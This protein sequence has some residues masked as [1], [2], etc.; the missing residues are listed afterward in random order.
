MMLGYTCIRNTDPV[1]GDNTITLG[2]GLDALQTVNGTDVK[3]RFTVPPSGNVEIDFSCMVYASS[4]ELTFSLST[5]ATG[6]YSAL[7]AIHEYDGV[8]IKPDETDYI[9]ANPKWVVS[10]LTPGTDTTWYIAAKSSSASSYIYHGTSRT[11]LYTQPII[12]KATALP[13][14]E[15]NQFV[16]GT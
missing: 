14:T 3:I 9:V 15:A 10:G 4:R 6:S 5:G 13:L 1:A 16:T 2:T 7:D 12:I 11:G 8:G